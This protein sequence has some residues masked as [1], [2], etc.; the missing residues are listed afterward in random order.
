M[1]EAANVIGHKY[2]VN[3]WIPD[4]VR[5]QADGW[6][7]AADTFNR[8][9]EAS[10]KAGIQFAYHNH[11]FE[12]FEVDGKLPYDN[13][14]AWTDPKLVQME[15]DLCWIYVG[16][17]DPF[18]YFDRWPGRFPLVHVKDLTSIPKVSPSGPQDFGS[19]L[20]EMTD[21]G[22]GVLAWKKIFAQSGKAGIKHYF[23]EHDNPKDPF[24][25]IKSSYDYL[26]NIR[27]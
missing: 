25:S 1:L 14:L 22:S 10:K 26:T 21:V 4:E 12:F 18:K 3:P 2:L 23:V 8:V 27:F 11:W 19:S 5:K 17:Q 6:K 15:L 20:K 9:G 13:L 24:A 7:Q 16:G